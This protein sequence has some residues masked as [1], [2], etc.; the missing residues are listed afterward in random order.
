LKKRLRY[1]ISPDCLKVKTAQQQNADNAY[2]SKGR[3]AEKM[4]WIEFVLLAI[5]AVVGAY[6]RYRIVDSPIAVG[7]LSINV[8]IINIVGSFLLG[9][10]SVLALTLNLDAKYTLFVAIGFCGSFTTMSSFALETTNLMETN[11]FNLVALNIIVN[12]GLSISAILAG[13]FIGDVL[14]E[15]ILR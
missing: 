2:L 12:V 10:F 7:G 11:R 8:L 3:Y 5:G 13:R 15:K 6:L 4:K 9:I 14:M 1:G